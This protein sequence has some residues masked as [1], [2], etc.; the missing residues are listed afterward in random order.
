MKRNGS[1]IM[2]R[3]VEAEENLDLIDTL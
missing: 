1:D 2:K 3:P